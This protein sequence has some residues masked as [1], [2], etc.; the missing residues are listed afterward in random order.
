MSFTHILKYEIFDHQDG[1]INILVNY[2][3]QLR[4]L[5][6]TLKSFQMP[7]SDIMKVFSD[8]FALVKTFFQENDTLY[9][10]SSQSSLSLF[11]SSKFLTCFNPE[12]IKVIQERWEHVRNSD[13]SGE[14]ASS[15][16]TVSRTC[17]QK[18]VEISTRR[19][20]HFD[21]DNL[22]L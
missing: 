7:V 6:L 15:R 8:E 16:N 2:S 19:F 20:R 3:Y 22:F 14:T 21:I 5:V 4:V 11:K 17:N 13:C 10:E 12:A 18:A 9:A 1:P